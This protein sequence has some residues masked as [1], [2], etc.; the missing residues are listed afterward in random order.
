M[1]FNNSGCFRVS[2]SFKV[3]F[4]FILNIFVLFDGD[5]VCTVLGCDDKGVVC[6]MV[7]D[8]CGGEVVCGECLEG[9]FCI[10]GDV[11]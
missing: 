9:E 7:D 3:G 6:G 5:G 10:C 8:G 11:Y 1:W 4:I 2:E